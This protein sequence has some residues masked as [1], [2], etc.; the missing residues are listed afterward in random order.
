MVVPTLALVAACGPALVFGIPYVWREAPVEI[1]AAPAMAISPYS[2]DSGNKFVPIIDIARVEGTGDAVIAG[3][4]APGAIV[5]LLHNGEVHGRTVADQS[6]QFVMV[7]PRLPS[8]HY[9][10][11]LRSRQPDGRQAVSKQIVSIAVQPRLKDQPV[12][13]EPHRTAATSGSDG[14]SP[15]V[16]VVPKITTTVVFRGDSLWR[17]SRATYGTGMRYVVIYTVNRHQIR[18]SN[19]IYPGQI[20]VLPKKAR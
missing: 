9:E 14:S 4:A 2:P 20:F 1:R 6:G 10:V 18:D 7:P 15:S 13:E 16:E 3:R 17:I 12:V 19:R 8:G 5:E 11:T